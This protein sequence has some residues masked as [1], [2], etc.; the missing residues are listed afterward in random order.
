M[1]VAFLTSITTLP[2]LLDLLNP[3]GENEPVGYAFLAPVDDFLEK[4]RVIIIVGTLLVALAGLPLLYFMKFDFNPINL[5]NT[6]AESIA[7]F[8]DLR[9][10][11]NTGAN[12]INVMTNSEADAKKIE[13]K[14][15][16]VPEVLRVMSLDSFVPDNQPAKLKLIAQAA[17]VVG[18]ALNPDSVDAAPSDEENVEALKSSVE[19]LRKTAGDAK[20]A[21]R[22]R[23]AAAGGRA[24]EACR[25]QPG[26]ARQGAGRFRH[27]AQ[28]RVRPAQE[29]AA[30]PA[31]QPEKPAGRTG[32]RLEDQGRPDARRGAAEGRSQRQRQSP[33]VCRCRAGGGAECDRRAGLDPQI[34]RHR[35]EGVRPCRHLGAARDQPVAL[36]DAAADHRRAADAGAATGGRRGDAGNLRA[37][38]AAAQLRQHRRAGRCCSASASPSR[39]IM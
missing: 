34:R 38:R 26:D 24:V 23:R 14:L 2:A 27:P 17:K 20:S 12:A 30:G 25:F 11:P 1:L 8:L 21:G 29:H 28:D 31:G 36:A 32:Q 7:T 10:D 15:E 39:S 3:P 19:S 33:Q 18:P 35:G 16:K 9:K 4:H 6:N 22:G 5:R 37:D 13:A